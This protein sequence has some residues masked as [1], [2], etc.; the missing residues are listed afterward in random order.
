MTNELFKEQK[1]QLTKDLNK[2][3]N[4]ALKFFRK[5]RKELNKTDLD[6]LVNDEF[7][8]DIC[9]YE[10]GKD[11]T[12]EAL[13][14]AYF[15]LFSYTRFC[16]IKSFNK[17]NMA[18]INR[19]LEVIKNTKFYPYAKEIIELQYTNALI[20]LEAEKELEKI[21]EYLG[22][23]NALEKTISS[24]KN[25]ENQKTFNKFI[26]SL[27]NWKEASIN[28]DINLV[29]NGVNYGKEKVMCGVMI[30]R[31]KKIHIMEV[32]ISFDEKLG[33]YYI[34]VG[35]YTQWR[36]SDLIVIDVVDKIPDEV[37]AYFNK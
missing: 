14:E 36:K 21:G 29:I 23:R 33:E 1:K 32:G 19:N 11:I 18:N 22:K 15:S 27:E 28:Q 34:R 37:K 9:K 3:S 5:N 12:D 6:T 10:N 35:N 31:G 8:N 26:S 2:F 4:E 16:S 17:E 13:K 30:G 7:Y 24:F 25:D 20:L